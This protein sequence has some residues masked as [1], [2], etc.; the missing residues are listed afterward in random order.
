MPS[1]P[2][3]VSVSEVRTGAFTV[4]PAT[5]TVSEKTVPE[6]VEPSPNARLKLCPA[7]LEVELALVVHKV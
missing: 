6:T 1:D 4:N 2:H 7:F 3:S 5:V